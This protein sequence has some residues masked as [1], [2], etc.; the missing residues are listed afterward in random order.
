MFLV[1]IEAVFDQ[2]DANLYISSLIKKGFIV[3]SI[4]FIPNISFTCL[5][6]SSAFKSLLSINP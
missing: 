4:Y 6:I 3:D 1:L 2:F 5:I